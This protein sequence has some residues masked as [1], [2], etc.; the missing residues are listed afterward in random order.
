MAEG[1]SEQRS[2]RARPPRVRRSRT[3]LLPGLLTR[4]VERDPQAIALVHDGGTVS[5]SELDARSSRLA[6]FLIRRGAGP[7]TVVAIGVRRSVESVVALWAVAKT[8]AA[9]L[10][11][12]P[13]YPEQRIRHMLEDSGA[14][15]GIT[16]ASAR[17]LL[18]G[19]VD[20]VVLDDDVTEQSIQRESA[21]P[22][23]AADR[24]SLLLPEHPAYVIYTSGSTGEPK[25]V[26]VTHSGIEALSGHLSSRLETTSESRTLH[27]V[28]P[29]FDASILEYLIA[30]GAAGSMVLAAPDIYGG[31]ELSA[32]LER[33]SVTHAFFTPG[34]L[35][36]LDPSG[37]D[38]LRVM[39]VG[40][41][42][43][44]RDLVEKWAPGRSFFNAYGPTET[45]IVSN[46][47]DSLAPGLDLPLG[48]S[49]PGFACRV[50]DSRS[51]E[52]PS[53]V[54]G[55]LY[56]SG[57]GLACGY[58][59]RRG[60]TASRFVADPFGA[61]GSRMYRT[62]DVVRRD[63]R[64]S[65]TFVG[66]SDF[67]VKVRGYRVELGEIDTALSA[68]ANVEFA[69]T[70]SF[71]ND[72]NTILVSYVLAAGNAVVDGEQLRRSVGEV[73]PAHM[74]PSTVV[75]IDRI[76]LTPAGKVDRSALTKPR[77][78]ARVHR[79]PSTPTEVVVAD[80]YA[81]VL[82]RD[83]VGADDDFFELGGNSLI[84][85]QVAARVGRRLN[86][87]V[88][89]KL[90]FED[91]TVS[92]LARLIDDVD[93]EEM[94]APL[95]AVERPE[96]IPL[97]FAQQ[98]IWFLNRFDP[99]SSAN[100]IPVAIRL[101]GVLDVAALHRAVFD[102]L[103]RHE[104]LRTMYPELDGI[105]YQHIV[106]A[107]DVPLS[108]EP[109]AV[110]PS[111]V[112]AAVRERVDTGFDLTTAVP[113]RVHL[114]RLSPTEHVLV[115]TVHHIAADGFSIGPLT[116]DVMTAYGAR[117]HGVEPDWEP[118]P[119]QYADFAVWQR[120]VLGEESDPNS[121]AHKQLSFW[122]ELSPTRP[123]RLRTRSTSR[124][125]KCRRSEERRSPSTST[126][127][128]RRRSPARRDATNLRSSCLP[129]PRSR[130]F[131]LGLQDSAMS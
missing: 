124:D 127:R 112:Q 28:S 62:G 56:L 91:P 17:S 88:P 19:A 40:G 29:S 105:A 32:L 63:V 118:L 34:V 36:S 2:R 117:L 49:I 39:V 48:Q 73:L 53:G 42:A 129:T 103:V 21:E 26:A 114:L 75:G 66:R 123:R 22:I 5:Y 94:S 78:E 7:E 97:S 106:D 58:L 51:K 109:V 90:L 87:R 100:N 89:A 59:G 96:R 116:R 84:G 31:E 79:E 18:P 113:L 108:M 72:G 74:V 55:E 130:W 77:M 86:K 111:E 122:R 61:P 121:D 45:T 3:L 85:T 107:S 37:L 99:E 131:C 71:D 33:H 20:W 76:P 23:V 80:V 82:G 16:S 8:G 47:S 128:W 126:Q 30:F 6:R 60:L 1:S 11:V 15:A 104:S 110:L 35:A 46:M 81:T 43:Y 119:V 115:M 12:D 69:L 52:V 9:F 10:P 57:P 50:L 14:T 24:V 54:A 120:T 98:R 102:V 25:G 95:T 41:E 38:S 27:F 92:G 83:E 70:K 64:G 44:G 4:S 65:L 67:Q 13:D 93:T 125:R 68:L 101:S